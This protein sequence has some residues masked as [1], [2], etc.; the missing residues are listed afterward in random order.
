MTT[1][2]QPNNPLH[3]ITLETILLHLVDRYGWDE[4]GNLI[5]INCFILNKDIPGL[6]K[7]LFQLT[8]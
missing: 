1:Q 2:P 4:L 5:N 7:S 3:G 6:F 8:A